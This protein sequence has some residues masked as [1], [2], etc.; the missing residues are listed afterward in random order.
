[1]ANK[2]IID[3]V[4]N[5]NKTLYS[6]NI[7]QASA[8]A[9]E[10]IMKNS[11]TKKTVDN[12]TVV[13]IGFSGYK[14]NLF[15][16]NFMVS[17]HSVDELLEKTVDQINSNLSFELNRQGSFKNEE[18][19]KDP[20]DIRKNEGKP[21]Q[22]ESPA[23]FRKGNNENRKNIINLPKKD[24]NLLVKNTISAKINLSHEKKGGNLTRK[25]EVGK[26]LSKK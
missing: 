19:L 16:K 20:R 24:K 25:A 13:L 12:I 23:T 5:T 14:K 8:E 21:K 26:P 4:W 22:N 15:S 18:F 9:V 10:S 1:M 6:E 3:C 2:E 17:N 11:I 7:H